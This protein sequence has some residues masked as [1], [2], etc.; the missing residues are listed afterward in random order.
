MAARLSGVRVGRV[1]TLA[2][3][4]SGMFAALAGVLMLGYAGTVFIGVG[5]AFILPSV[6]AVVVGGT[7]LAGG[8]GGYTGTA[9]GAI[10]LTLLQSVLTSVDVPAPVRQMVFGLAL[11]GFMLAYG[12]ERRLRQ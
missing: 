6:I 8:V 11:L 4:V 3:G 7:A 10:T 12:R 9:L 2:Y 5:E 1:R